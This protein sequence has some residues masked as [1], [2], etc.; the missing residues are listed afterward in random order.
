M[1]PFE[2]QVFFCMH[3]QE[4]NHRLNFLWYFVKI[5][6]YLLVWLTWVLVAVPRIFIYRMQTLS[7][8]VVASI[9]PTRDRSNLDRLHW[10]H[11][12]LALDYQKVSLIEIVFFLK[13]TI[14]TI[15]SLIH[16][17]SQKEG[18]F[19]FSLPLHTY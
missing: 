3:V 18:E 11:G 17:Y 6:I 10:E 14:H 19:I 5:H 16:S 4:F 9:S 13:E 12:V 7:C 1:F 15:L 8:L 2:Y